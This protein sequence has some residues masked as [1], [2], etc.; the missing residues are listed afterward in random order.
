MTHNAFPA[1]HKGCGHE[2]P[3]VKTDDEKDQNVIMTI[4]NRTIEQHL[5]LGSRETFCEALG[6]TTGLE[7]VKCTVGSFM[8]SQKMSV[9]TLWRG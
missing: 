3:M 5:G 2:G 8:R 9:K 7:N 6:H 1:W 4:R